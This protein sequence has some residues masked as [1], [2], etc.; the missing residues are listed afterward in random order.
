M[1]L[2]H[3]P[4]ASAVNRIWELVRNTD[5]QTPIRDLLGPAVCVLTLPAGNS[6]AAQCES[7]RPGPS[8]EFTLPEALSLYRAAVVN[9]MWTQCVVSPHTSLPFPGWL[10]PA[11]PLVPASAPAP[12]GNGRRPLSTSSEDSSSRGSSLP[13]HLCVVHSP[14]CGPVS[15]ANWDQKA[16]GWS[17]SSV[18]PEHAAHSRPNTTGHPAWALKR[19]PQVPTPSE[20]PPEAHPEAFLWQKLQL[21]AHM[22]FLLEPGG[23]TR[24]RKL[25]LPLGRSVDTTYR[26]R[27]GLETRSHGGGSDQQ[28]LLPHPSPGGA[29]S[30]HPL[31]SG[32]SHSS[33]PLRPQAHLQGLTRAL[34]PVFQTV[35]KQ[36]GPGV[37]EKGHGA[38]SARWAGISTSPA[39]GFFIVKWGSTRGLKGRKSWPPAEFLTHVWYLVNVCGSES[40]YDSSMSDKT[41]LLF[42]S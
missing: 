36:L 31:V 35:R 4:R 1:V 27:S 29:R 13:P 32:G 34:G 41:S 10:P 22:T 19:P 37:Q 18:V 11:W 9:A 21:K 14:V 23:L 2:T 39:L 25:F 38:R 5:S 3:G 40:P 26:L 20:K 16:R 33:T 12:A 42:L 6:E 7:C 15:P 24:R 28:R 30:H 8:R 17:S